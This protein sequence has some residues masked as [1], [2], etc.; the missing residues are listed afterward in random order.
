MSA[1]SAS[2]SRFA[3]CAPVGAIA[4]ST[5]SRAVSVGIRLNCWKMKP[6]V[7]SLRSASSPSPSVGRA[8]G[9]RTRSFRRGPVERAEHLEQRRLARAG[10]ADDDDELAARDVERDPVEGS[11]PRPLRGAVHARQILDSVEVVSVRQHG[12]G[13]LLRWGAHHSTLLRASAGRS[14]AARRPPTLPAT[15]PPSTARPIA[16]ATISRSM[17]APRVTEVTASPTLSAEPPGPGGPN[18][19]CAVATEA[20]RLMPRAPISAEPQ[21]RER[22]PPR[23]R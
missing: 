8:R 21:G 23:R 22:S 15:R 11:H 9:P 18:P 7:R 14:R 13:C 10:G 17:G 6:S 12:H 2:S 20:S 5:F 3:E 4:T 1:P 19:D 16:S